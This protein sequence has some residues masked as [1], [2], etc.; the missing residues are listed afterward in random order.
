MNLKGDYIRN[1]IEGI[2]NLTDGAKIQIQGPDGKTKWMSIS[3]IRLQNI[4]EVL[5]KK[6][7]EVVVKKV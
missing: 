1:Q 3:F 4:A 2:G 7:N 5:V 6:D